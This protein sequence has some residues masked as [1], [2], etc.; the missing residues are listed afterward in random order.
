ML[1]L[2]GSVALMVAVVGSAT[3][4]SWTPASA[5]GS[6]TGGSDEHRT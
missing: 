5:T 2:A 6:R 3:V 1:Q 4:W